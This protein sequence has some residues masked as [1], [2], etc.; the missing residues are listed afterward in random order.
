MF[1]EKNFATRSQ[2]PDYLR[3]MD[4]LVNH[5]EIDTVDAKTLFMEIYLQANEEA[6]GVMPIMM[7]AMMFTLLMCALPYL[8]RYYK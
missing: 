1:D 3:R 8:W 7:Q 4:Q 2:I 6:T 5:Q